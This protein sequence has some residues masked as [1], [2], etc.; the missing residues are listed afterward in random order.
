MRGRRGG[1]PLNRLLLALLLV[2]LLAPQA[3]H[4]AGPCDLGPTG[5]VAQGGYYVETRAN[6][7]VW[8]YEESNGVPDLQRGGA[9]GFG[10]KDRCVDDPL[11][12][13]DEIVF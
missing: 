1:A 12:T 9:N 10:D 6:N 5:R 7:D 8:V 4:A 11:V 3:A 13:P 2:P